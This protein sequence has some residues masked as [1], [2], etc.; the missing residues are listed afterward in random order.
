[1]LR[2][3][4]A[5]VTGLSR[6]LNRERMRIAGHPSVLMIIVRG[7]TRHQAA[8]VILKGGAGAVLRRPSLALL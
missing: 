4:S 3:N 5:Q 1:M 8:T 7:V 6:G 2:M